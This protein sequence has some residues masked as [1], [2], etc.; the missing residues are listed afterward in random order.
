MPHFA[1]ARGGI[2]FVNKKP[3]IKFDTGL[4]LLFTSIITYP[5]VH[6]DNRRADE[7]DTLT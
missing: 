3:S 1:T 7:T 4:D 5:A 6:A 2:G